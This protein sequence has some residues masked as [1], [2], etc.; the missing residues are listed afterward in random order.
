ML[1]GLETLRL[2]VYS[3][4][5]RR[6]NSH[7]GTG[8]RLKTPS[9]VIASG[10]GRQQRQ[11]ELPARQYVDDEVHGRV[12]HYHGVADGRVVVMP[13]T[14]D[15]LRRVDESPEQMVDKGGRLTANEHED[16]D[17][18]HERYVVLVAAL[19]H[20]QALLLLL[21][22]RSDQVHVEE[23]EHDQ[24]AAVHEHEVE[25]V[26]VDDPIV[27][28][29]AEL[30]D[31]VALARLVVADALG[32]LLVLEEARYVVEDREQ[33]DVDDVP[34]GVVR[35]ADLDRLERL[36]DGHVAVQRDEHRQQ[37]G[38]R[39]RDLVDR[40]EERQQVDVELV[41]GAQRLR[42]RI[43]ERQ[44]EEREGRQQDKRVGHRQ[45]PQQVG[46]RP[47][48]LVS[49]QDRERHDVADK[50]ECA[51]STHADRVDQEVEQSALASD[52]ELRRAGLVER[53]V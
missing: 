3:I 20:L 36:A 51:E 6:Q 17:D 35:R 37:D 42:V 47:F 38:A 33:R 1:R 30:A 23:G 10:A 49:P 2:V 13:M 9:D 26:V 48:A 53:Y 14:A 34:L 45:R 19:A 44:D 24:R 29:V 31:G 46:R 12:Q 43:H 16:N 25:Y 22:Q 8:C 4:S 39:V 28:V 5:G 40:P 41:P 21:L 18:Q 15:P 7:L 52:V 27:L 32:R 50:A 11:P